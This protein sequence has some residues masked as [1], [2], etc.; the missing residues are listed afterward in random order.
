MDTPDHFHPDAIDGNYIS[1]DGNV[2]LGHY[3]VWRRLAGDVWVLVRPVQPDLKSVRR[4]A[5][6][7]AHT[8]GEG[9]N[10]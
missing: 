1:D 9:G 5:S 2:Y 6:G 8:E 3:G 4:G 7:H 10:P